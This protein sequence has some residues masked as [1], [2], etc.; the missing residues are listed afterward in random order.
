M[1]WTEPCEIVDVNYVLGVTWR[2]DYFNKLK[3]N[4]NSNILIMLKL[5]IAPIQPMYQIYTKWAHMKLRENPCHWNVT[6]LYLR[7]Y[8]FVWNIPFNI[9]NLMLFNSIDL[10]PTHTW[11]AACNH[12]T[13][14]G[15][16]NC[17]NS[18]KADHYKD[19]PSIR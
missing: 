16:K 10:L 19:Y 15:M 9:I 11:G 7:L 1:L 6:W 17:L 8:Y 5:E 12:T 18:N 4:L 3:I 2:I 14:P 13:M